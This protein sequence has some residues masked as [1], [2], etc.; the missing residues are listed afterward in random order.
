MEC[1]ALSH[2]I[3]LGRKAD[4][5]LRWRHLIILCIT[6][7]NHDN[8]HTQFYQVFWQPMWTVMMSGSK[9]YYKFNAPNKDIDWLNH[10]SK[11]TLQH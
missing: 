9:K 4:L 1:T 7:Y 3:W 11:M 5:I 6:I 10:N 8:C 2:L